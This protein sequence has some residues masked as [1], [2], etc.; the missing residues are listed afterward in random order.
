[1]ADRAFMKCPVCRD[2]GNTN[3]PELMRNHGDPNFFC[4]LGH[5]LTPERLQMMRPEMIKLQPVV[6]PRDTDVKATFWCN[7]DVLNKSKEALGV[8]W[9]RTLEAVLQA[10]ITG[11]YILIDGAQ[12]AKLRAAGIRTGADMVASVEESKRLASENEEFT[13]QEIRREAARRRAEEEL[14]VEL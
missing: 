2:N 4:P 3:P 13:R 14:G 11:D 7:P 9:D 8:R 1:M 6:K 12:A 5:A 10:A